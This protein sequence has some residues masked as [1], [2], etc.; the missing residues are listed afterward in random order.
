MTLATGCL[1]AVAQRMT[2]SVRKSD[3]VARIGGDEFAV[4]LPAED[5]NGFS[6][7]ILPL[8]G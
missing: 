2:E 3:T 6:A 4:L 8:K 1:Q 5:F 7:A